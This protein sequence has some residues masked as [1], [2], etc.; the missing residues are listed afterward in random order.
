LIAATAILYAPVLGYEFVRFDDPR[1][2]SEN[3]YIA[4]GLT[5]ET[6]E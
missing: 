3:T 5:W 2:V 4:D 1:Y 6:I